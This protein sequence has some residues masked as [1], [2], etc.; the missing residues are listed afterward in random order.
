M[1]FDQTL[2]F[3]RFFPSLPGSRA[4]HRLDLRHGRRDALRILGDDGGVGV[5]QGVARRVADAAQ[6]ALGPDVPA[7]HVVQL[8]PD[9]RLDVRRRHVVSHSITIIEF[10]SSIV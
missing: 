6:D 7:G 1:L 5:A 3:P 10:R 9:Q 8:H 2:D 4:H